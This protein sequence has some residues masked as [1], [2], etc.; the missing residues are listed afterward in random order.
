MLAVPHRR[1]AGLRWLAVV[2]GTAV[3][4]AGALVGRPAW[5]AGGGPGTAD[6]TEVLARAAALTDAPTAG[7]PASRGALSLVQTPAAAE[8]PEPATPP[9]GPTPCPTRPSLS[10]T[11]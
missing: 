9:E 7:L 2:A 3:L 10:A 1:A 6:A 8:Q 11:S 4:V 5:S